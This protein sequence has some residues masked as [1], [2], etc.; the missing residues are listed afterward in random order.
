MITLPYFPSSGMLTFMTKKERSI[1][2]PMIQGKGLE[3]LDDNLDTKLKKQMNVIWR[4]ERVKGSEYK[5]LP[6]MSLSSFNF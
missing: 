3:V 1:F 6:Q 4:T 2:L 5:V